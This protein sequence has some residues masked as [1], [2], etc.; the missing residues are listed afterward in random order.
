VTIYDSKLNIHFKEDDKIIARNGVV[1]TIKCIRDRG[2]NQ[3]CILENGDQRRLV[4]VCIDQVES[5][6]KS[7]QSVTT[8]EMD[9]PRGTEP[10]QE[11]GTE[12]VQEPEPLED[13][14]L[15]ENLK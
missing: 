14:I 5:V 1:G 6:T 12:P 2:W 3:I 7:S 4:Y 10:E 8:M 11:T 13:G 9:E 15:L